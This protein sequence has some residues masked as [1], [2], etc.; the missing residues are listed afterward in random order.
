MT[1]LGT[2]ARPLTSLLAAGAVAL[3]GAFAPA[4]PAHADD[5]LIKFLA[6]A[7]AVGLIVKSLDDSSKRRAKPGRQH[8]SD[9]HHFDDRH[10]YRDRNR[11]R[12]RYHRH[13]GVRV[14]IHCA[15]P[16]RGHRASDTYYS[17]RCLLRA[18]MARHLPASCTQNVRSNHGYI[19]VYSGRCMARSGLTVAIR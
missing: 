17:R 16:T 10:H 18:G 6:G 9:R 8:Y 14:P 15:L 19:T 4:T 3:A 11:D 13:H 1:P 12:S 5:D 2:A 7:A